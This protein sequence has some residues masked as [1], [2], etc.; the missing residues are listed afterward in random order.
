VA[1]K[2][3]Q[4]RK[5]K[6]TQR[7]PAVRQLS[8]AAQGAAVLALGLGLAAPAP[9][10]ASIVYTDIADVTIKNNQLFGFDI[11]N[12]TSPPQFILLHGSYIGQ[13][14]AVGLSS[15]FGYG[16]GNFVGTYKTYVS[17]PNSYS[18]PVISFLTKGDAINSTNLYYIGYLA[19]TVNGQTVNEWA[20]KHGYAGL[21]FYDQEDNL[22]YGWVELSMPSDLSSL[23]I[24]GY[25]YETDADTAIAA[26]AV[27][28]PSSLLLLATGALGVLAYRRR[29]QN[30]EQQPD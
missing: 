25:A 9:V 14:G 16:Y 29:R 13:S 23:T 5:T 20:G 17:Y 2:K 26:G 15:P 11:T 30:R 7:R 1:R 10:E 18:I 3:E 28:V 24:Y 6:N 27:P 19:G 22:H 8:V 12:G 4:V 21:L